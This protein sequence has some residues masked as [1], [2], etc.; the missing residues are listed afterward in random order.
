MSS[1]K[2]AEDR[3][4]RVMS[5]IDSDL[6]EK[7]IPKKQNIELKKIREIEL[8]IPE[9][10]PARKVLPWAA[11]AAAAIALAGGGAFLISRLPIDTS[12]DPA[13]SQPPVTVTSGVTTT[14]AATTPADPDIYTGDPW[15]YE[16]IPEGTENVFI[17]D[18]GVYKVDDTA[19]FD[20]VITVEGGAANWISIFR[21][22]AAEAEYDFR[23]SDPDVILL[24]ENYVGELEYTDGVPESNMQTNFPKKA[25][26][27]S[28]GY[29]DG[30][31]SGVSLYQSEKWLR[32]EVSAEELSTI[33][34]YLADDLAVTPETLDNTT[35]YGLYYVSAEATLMPQRYYELT[36]S[37]AKI[38]DIANAELNSSE[39]DYLANPGGTYLRTRPLPIKNSSSY[40]SFWCSGTKPLAAAIVTYDETTGEYTSEHCFTESVAKDIDE[41]AARQAEFSGLAESAPADSGN[42][43]TRRE[44]FY[45]LDSVSLEKVISSGAPLMF[46]SD[47]ENIAAVTADSDGGIIDATGDGENIQVCGTAEVT[48]FPAYDELWAYPVTQEAYL[49]SAD[50]VTAALTDAEREEIAALASG[51]VTGLTNFGDGTVG[52]AASYPFECAGVPYCY[53]FALDKD[54]NIIAYLLAVRRG[55]SWSVSQSGGLAPG[56]SERLTE[57]YKAGTPITLTM[58]GSNLYCDP[59]DGASFVIEQMVF[60]KPSHARFYR[61]QD[62]QPI[63]VFSSVYTTG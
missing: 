1:I 41:E 3:L 14:T 55:G 30:R 63:T 50:S 58:F 5:D 26:L 39:L 42:N 6:V 27:Y 15:E 60:N 57:L 38:S 28:H 8:N 2:R 54:G 32:C 46:F 18:G 51:S 13:F 48:G 23:L 47:G 11:G 34:E 20:Y 33:K 52:V 31:N 53:S 37:Y 59:A 4:I 16:K 62:A 22:S 44:G 35:V 24:S 43:G 9:V 49:S 10:S 61:E 25:W 45:L 21:E 40:I 17:L 29:N 7:A 12:G 19:A 56:A 36:P